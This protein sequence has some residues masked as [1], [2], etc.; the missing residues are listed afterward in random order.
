MAFLEKHL[1]N[2][3]G[4]YR[5]FLDT[6]RVA[7]LPLYSAVQSSTA[8]REQIAELLL[9]DSPGLMKPP[10]REAFLPRVET[11]D[12]GYQTSRISCGSHALLGQGRKAS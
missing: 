8:L 9:L 3:S 11:Q 2:L 5:C 7:I 10:L 6:P 1:P 12:D 4:S